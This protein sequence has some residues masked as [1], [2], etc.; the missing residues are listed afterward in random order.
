MHNPIKRR[1]LHG[2][3]DASE[4]AYGACVYLKTVTRSGNIN[5][6]LV[7]AKSRV[8]PVKK[9]CTIPRLE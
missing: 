7:T 1:F 2:F 6:S 3:T 8:A 5:V 9:K 4:K